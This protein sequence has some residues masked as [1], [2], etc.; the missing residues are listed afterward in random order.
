MFNSLRRVYYLPYTL[1]LDLSLEYIINLNLLSIDTNILSSLDNVHFLSNT[2]NIGILST[3]DKV[4]FFS[5]TLES[6]LNVERS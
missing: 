6:D 4:Y 5:N 1:E 2:L 3:L